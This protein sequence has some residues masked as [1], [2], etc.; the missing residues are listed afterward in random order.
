MNPYSGLTVQGKPVMVSA[1][2]ICLLAA[3]VAV[4][5]SDGL[6]VGWWGMEGG[7]VGVGGDV[8]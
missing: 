6:M 3:A 8:Q 7:V 4:R 2:A 5:G 1:S